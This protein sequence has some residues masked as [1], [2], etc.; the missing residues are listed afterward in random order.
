MIRIYLLCLQT[1]LIAAGPGA[2]Y[3]MQ[4]SNVFTV[5]FMFCPSKANLWRFKSISCDR[6]ERGTWEG[7][8][9]RNTTKKFNEHS[10]AAKKFNKTPSPQQVIFKRV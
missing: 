8:E 4:V 3:R 5:N 2:Q 6:N 9:H 10:I 7:S 1:V